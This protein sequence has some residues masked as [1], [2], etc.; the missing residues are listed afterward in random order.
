VLNLANFYRADSGTIYA[1]LQKALRPESILAFN[2]ALRRNVSFQLPIDVDMRPTTNEAFYDALLENA[3]KFLIIY[4][5]LA[6]GNEFNVPEIS[7]R[8][9]GIIH[10]FVQKFLANTGAWEKVILT[11]WRIS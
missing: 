9:G 6:K 5:F 4:R 7:N 3:Q 8:E 10:T 2:D 11:G 1:E